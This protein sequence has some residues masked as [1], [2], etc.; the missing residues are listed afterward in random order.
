VGVTPIVVWLILRGNGSVEWLL[1]PAL[2]LLFLFP[3]AMAYVIVVHRAMDVR[4][5]IRQGL[6]YLLATGGIKVLQVVVS[7]A[8]IVMAATIGAGQNINLAQRIVILLFE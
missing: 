6:R 5:V 1:L 8:I 7:I 2:M 3:V 4:V